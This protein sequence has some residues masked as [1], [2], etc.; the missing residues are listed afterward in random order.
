MA[1]PARRGRGSDPEGAQG[2]RGQRSTNCPTQR[3]GTQDG[4]SG[5]GA[6]TEA[7]RFPASAYLTSYAPGMSLPTVSGPLPAA[8]A[9]LLGLVA[10][11]LRRY[12][13]P[14]TAERE[15]MGSKSPS[16]P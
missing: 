15:Q 3:M 16:G 1:A 14:R 5:V 12:R 13:S 9:V 6:T 11:A 8:I 4:Q 10:I 2:R 7:R